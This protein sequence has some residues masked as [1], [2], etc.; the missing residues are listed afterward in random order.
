MREI[1]IVIGR[2][3]ARA[4]ST[5]LRGFQ[6]ARLCAESAAGTGHEVRLRWHDA[7]IA[8]ALAIV[9]KSV[10]LPP[11]RDALPR[12]RAA[13]CLLLI[14]FLDMLVRPGLARQADGF[15]ACSRAQA[16]H[17]REAYPGRPVIDLPHHAD[18]DIPESPGTW[19]AWRCGY[20]GDPANT[21]HL[22]AV[23]A[24]GL[25]IAWAT[26]VRDENGWRAALAQHN[27]HYAVRPRSM[28]GGRFKPFTKGMLAARVGAVAVVDESD[29]EAMALLG[30][31]Y[32]F[33]MPADCDA[34][35]LVQRLS[36]MR[37]GFG[38]AAWQL[39]RS[40]MEPLRRIG[41]AAHQVALLR[42]ALFGEG[43]V[44]SWLR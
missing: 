25:V 34:A 18:L 6:L 42:E 10:L 16:A 4:G 15:I 43:P 13:G 19:D 5:R 26:P 41:S 11:Y 21:A 28:L 22:D 36:E 3:H 27:L 17:L 7:P 1:A 38:D 37:S 12:L 35:T 44:A 24:A 8:G 9:H 2:G 40:R 20:F 14:D 29:E 30:A 31:D 23:V 33:A 39:A 32:P